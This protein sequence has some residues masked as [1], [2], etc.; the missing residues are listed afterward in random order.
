MTLHNSDKTNDDFFIT[1]YTVH[2][3]MP[4]P[5]LTIYVGGGGKA[6]SFGPPLMDF[7]PPLSCH[8]VTLARSMK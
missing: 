3:N 6:P 5:F 7:A 2:W 4:G 8:V 1:S